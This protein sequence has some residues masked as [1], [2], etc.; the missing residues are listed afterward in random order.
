MNK[1]IVYT[2]GGSRSNPG[3]AATGYV[4][5]DESGKLLK[6]Y[7]EY[8]GIK[9]NNEA[10]YKAPIA[11][12]KKLRSLIGKEKAKQ[13]KVHI[14]SDSELM[15]SQ[16][17]GKYKITN[18]RIQPLFLELWNLKLDFKGVAFTSIPRERNREADALVNEALDNQL[19][20]QKLI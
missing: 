7:G 18:E 5:S 17:N 2:D 12:L 14:H 13:A 6:E 16:M 19:K 20:P 15:V 11:G 10:E 3:P 4:I 8:I 1:Y 9:T